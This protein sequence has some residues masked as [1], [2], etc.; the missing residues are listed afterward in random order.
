VS[1]AD[2]NAYAQWFSSNSGHR[3]RLPSAA[4]WQTIQR[5]SS[6]SGRAVAEWLRER[7]IAGASWRGGATR[8]L[9]PNRGYDDVGFRLVREL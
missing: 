9:D 5:N 8:T 2:A 3:Y 6:T 4:E 7:S 1:W